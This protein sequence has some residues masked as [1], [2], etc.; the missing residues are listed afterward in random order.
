MDPFTLLMSIPGIGPFLPYIMAFSFVCA[1]TLIVLPAPKAD[2][3]SW[4]R[5]IYA[6]VDF[7]ALNFNHAKTQT[8]VMKQLAP[9]LENLPAEV[10][11]T[12]VSVKEVV[13]FV[14]IVTTIPP[15]QPK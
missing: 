14:T 7:I 12:I 4:Y 1:G 2:A 15:V 6:V 10:P 11:A 8:A 13:P 9:A 3:P 5:A